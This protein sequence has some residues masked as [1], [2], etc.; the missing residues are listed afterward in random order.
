MIH[1]ILDIFHQVRA[2]IYE[3]LYFIFECKQNPNWKLIRHIPPP[4]TFCKCWPI[5]I[6]HWV[7]K[8]FIWRNKSDVNISEK[9]FPG[10]LYPRNL[11]RIKETSLLGLPEIVLTFQSQFLYSILPSFLQIYIWLQFCLFHS[12]YLLFQSF[13]LQIFILFSNY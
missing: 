5:F 12:E 9:S 7:E 13:M 10:V 4:Q 3:C 1:H 8:K 6:W 2:Q 11:K